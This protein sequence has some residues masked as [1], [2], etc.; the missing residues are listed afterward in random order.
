M[1]PDQ[2]VQFGAGD[3]ASRDAEFHLRP[4]LRSLE[5]LQA[6]S[7][8]QRRLMLRVQQRQWREE[9][10]LEP[11]I[12]HRLRVSGQLQPIR[13]ALHELLPSQLLP[14]SRF[15]LCQGPALLGLPFQQVVQQAAVTRTGG[16]GLPGRNLMD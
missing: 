2:P 10:G 13:F 16:K 3:A 6:Q 1:L 15:C 8:G 14:V 12:Q 11:R 9:G 7:L 5:G 4:C